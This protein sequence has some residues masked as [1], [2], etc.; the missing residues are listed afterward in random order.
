VPIIHF[1]LF[2]FLSCPPNVLWQEYL[3]EQFPAYTTDFDGK[4]RFSKTNTAK[5][6]ALDQTLGATVNTLLFIAVMSAFKGKDGKAI[7]RDCQRVCFSMSRIQKGKPADSSVQGFWPLAI[8][9]LKLWPLV[10]LLNLT[11]VPVNRRVVVG[12][13][14]GLFWGIYVSLIISE[15]SL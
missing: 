7:I 6:F 11:I 15:D 13:L 3:E 5:K 10:S 12:S 2:N 4:K 8:S 9:G 14:V 1:V